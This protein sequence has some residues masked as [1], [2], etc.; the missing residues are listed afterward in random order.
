MDLKEA[1]STNLL[2]TY[3]TMS[4]PIDISPIFFLK[5][6]AFEKLKDILIILFERKKDRYIYIF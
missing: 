1:P 6:I 2:W 4:I 5:I 3:A